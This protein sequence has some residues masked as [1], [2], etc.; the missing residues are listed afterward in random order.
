[1]NKFAIPAILATIV[2]VAG[3]F[4]FLP[5]EQASTVHAGATGV[6]GTQISEVADQVATVCSANLNTNTL[7]ATSTTDFLVMYQ[8][9]AATAAADPTIGDGTNTLAIT[10]ANGESITGT[11]A[12]PGGTIVTFSDPDVTSPADGCATVITETGGTSSVT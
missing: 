10:M 1:M 6:Q 2:M 3:M 5:V 8:I 9:T 12:Y 7:V 4:A 11:L